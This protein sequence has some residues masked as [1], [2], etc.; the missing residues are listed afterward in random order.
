MLKVQYKTRMLFA[1][2]AI[3]GTLGACGG[4]TQ[5]SEAQPGTTRTTVVGHAEA[6]EVA[7]DMPAEMAF[8]IDLWSD[9]GAT[10]A[11]AKC[12]AEMFDSNGWAPTTAEEVAAIQLDF[13]AE[14]SEEFAA[15]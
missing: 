4:S 2:V 14:Q 11:Q 3:A 10:P 13:T 6:I 7:E 9:M 15:C 5:D 1:A 8:S 12:Y